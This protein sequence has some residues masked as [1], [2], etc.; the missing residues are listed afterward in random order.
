[1]QAL[2]KAG[3]VLSYNVYVWV[4][5]SPSF[6][7]LPTIKR[8]VF[9]KDAKKGVMV[10]D[11]GAKKY[12]RTDE[13]TLA[14]SREDLALKKYHELLDLAERKAMDVMEKVKMWRNPVVME[15]SSE[16]PQKVENLRLK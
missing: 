9:V 1:V 8:Y 2:S 3:E 16:A 5:T 14:F 10:W 12:I 11:H 7:W 4:V 6:P 13:N 15:V